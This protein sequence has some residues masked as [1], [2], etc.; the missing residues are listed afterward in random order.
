MRNMNMRRYKIIFLIVTAVV[1][2]CIFSTLDTR[3][4]SEIST[5]REPYQQQL[6]QISLEHRDTE[7]AKLF[8]RALESLAPISTKAN[9]QLNPRKLLVREK[10]GLRWDLFPERYWEMDI[11]PRISGHITV[12]DVGANTG[13]FAIPMAE[14]GHTVISLEPNRNTCETLKNK[15]EIRGL[16]TQVCPFRLFRPCFDPTLSVL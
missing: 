15:L 12:L 8:K 4:I 3:N 9:H 11:L 6:Q 5:S 1:V 7:K 14:L 13:Q 16:T 10:V 2:V